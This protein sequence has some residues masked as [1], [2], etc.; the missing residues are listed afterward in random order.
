MYME[1]FA[2]I[3]PGKFKIKFTRDADGGCVIQQESMGF[4]SRCMSLLNVMVTVNQSG[5]IIDFA[6]GLTSPFSGGT[7]TFVGTD[8][9]GMLGRICPACKCYFRTN[10]LAKIIWCPYCSI[11]APNTAFTTQNQKQF[12]QLCINAMQKAMDSGVETI[13][14]SSEIVKDLSSNRPSWVVLETNQQNTYDHHDGK[15]VFNILG[16][17]G[18]C[19]ACGQRN[20]EMVFFKKMSLLEKRF[21]RV[22]SIIK[23]KRERGEEWKTIIERC[24]S[25]FESMANDM[26]SLLI[27]VPSTPKRKKEIER[28]NFQNLFEAN[29]AMKSWFGIEMLRNFSPDEQNFLKKMLNWRHIIVHN[30]GRVDEKYLK[31]TADSKVALNQSIRIGSEQ[32][33]RAIKLTSVLAKNLISELHS[34]K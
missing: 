14:D 12:M 9:E 2:E 29:D 32:A 30:S 18:T 33:H 6:R 17:Y 28:L 31:N 3:E 8:K 13:F 15:V 27:R 16:E 10:C 21:E 20:Y 7:L 22:N 25:E 23:D 5:V 24:V 1:E 34:L 19:P 4:T 26:R 11:R